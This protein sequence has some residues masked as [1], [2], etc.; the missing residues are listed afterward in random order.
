LALADPGRLRSRDE[1]GV[2]P[3][4]VDGDSRRIASAS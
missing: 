2:I 1:T 4:P 3:N